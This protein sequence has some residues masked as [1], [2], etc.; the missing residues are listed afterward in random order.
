MSAY[1]MVVDDDPNTRQ[2]LHF[3]L[4]NAGYAVTDAQDGL[5]ALEKLEKK[6]PDLIILDVLMPNM[7]GFT[8]MYHIR[9]MP[10]LADLPVIFLSSRADVAAEYSGLA[11]GAQQYLVKPFSVPILL[12]H[13]GDLLAAPTG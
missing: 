11:A 10:H 8:T 3:I 9:A 4:T 2:L 7:D 5:E 12:K 6:R 1:I 13:V